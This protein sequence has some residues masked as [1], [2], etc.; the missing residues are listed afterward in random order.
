MHHPKVLIAIPAKDEELSI[1]KVLT[2]I[3]QLF[4]E[5]EVLVINDGSQDAT[6]SIAREGGATV[7]EHN[8]NRGYTAAIQAGRVYALNNDCDFL[9]FIDADGQHRISDIN[10]ILEPLS[11][12]DADQV[13]GSRSL[14]RYECREPL[15]LKVSRWICSAL[16]SMKIKKIVTD[17]TS[18]FK[19]ENRKVTGFFKEVYDASNRIHQGNTNDIEEHLLAYK[20]G[21]RIM[22]VP[23]VMRCRENGTNW[24]GPRRLLTFPV[25]LIRTFLRNL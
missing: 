1:G 2:E 25:D 5:L 9:V 16:V 14:G 17:V 8:E 10:R 7:I 23:V 13:R 15:H 19:G 3:R 18:G 24:Y 11:Q 6:A 12:G 21:F 22:E 4:P 20:E